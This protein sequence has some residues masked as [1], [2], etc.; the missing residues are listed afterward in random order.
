MVADL[1]VDRRSNGHAEPS[2]SSDPQD[3]RERI[4]GI[5][6]GIRE[7]ALLEVEGEYRNHPAH[8]LQFAVSRHRFI[9]PT[10]E[11]GLV[12]FLGSG[13]IK[14]VGEATARQVVRRFGKRTLEVLDSESERLAE[15][16]GI[17]PARPGRS[18]TVGGKW[19][20]KG[21]WPP[22]CRNWG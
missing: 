6:P 3:A 19:P 7:G 9:H 15:L 22:F 2:A 18:G 20:E 12:G 16:K 5:L 13:L 14:G 4:T 1:D 11:E 8:G 17:S 10:T 21:S